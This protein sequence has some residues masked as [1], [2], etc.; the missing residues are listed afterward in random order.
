M[1]K[2]QDRGGRGRGEGGVVLDERFCFTLAPTADHYIT[3]G[4]HR[5]RKTVPRIPAEIATVANSVV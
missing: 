5:N 2:V 3:R 4:D 1:H